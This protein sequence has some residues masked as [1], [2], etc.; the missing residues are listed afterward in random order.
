MSEDF[1]TN[2]TRPT[3]HSVLAQDD[4]GDTDLTYAILSGNDGVFDIN[5]TTGQILVVGALDRETK[6][7]YSLVITATDSGP[8]VFFRGTA[9]V[10]MRITDVNDNSPVFEEAVYRGQITEGNTIESQFVVAVSAID[11]DSNDNSVVRY[12]L[13]NGTDYFNIDPQLGSIFTRTISFDRETRSSYVIVV[14]ARDM[15]TFRLNSSV[16]V[17]V[18]VQDINDGYPY[19]RPAQHQLDV[20]VPQVAPISISRLVAYDDDDGQNAELDYRISSNPHSLIL[21]DTIPGLIVASSNLESSLAGVSYTL[22]ISAVDRGTPRNTGSATI[23]INFV[24]NSD[25]RPR[26]SQSLYQVSLEEN[27]VNDRLV[28][29]AQIVY[30]GSLQVTFLGYHPSNLAVSSTIRSPTVS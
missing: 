8:S 3:P 29:F 2:E 15:G 25:S 6:E 4:D 11:A 1:Y 22:T 20:I 17:I 30:S 13:V 10:S 16:I 27:N 18:T 28:E 19:F 23:I 7:M 24:N 12:S 5:S 21:N 9:T 26:F 14:E